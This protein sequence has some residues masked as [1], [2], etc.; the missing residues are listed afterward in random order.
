MVVGLYT[1]VT[2]TGFHALVM[3]TWRSNCP[4]S[5]RHALIDDVVIAARCPPTHR[6][7]AMASTH[8]LPNLGRLTALSL[9]TEC[10]GHSQRLRLEGNLTEGCNLTF[11]RHS[12]SKTHDIWS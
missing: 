11:G 7:I 6:R 10:Q 8:L 9:T 5:L 3:M 2:K 1:V 4:F 12:S